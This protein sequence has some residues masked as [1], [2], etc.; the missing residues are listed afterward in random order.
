M[1]TDTKSANP[2]T[3]PEPPA[4]VAGEFNPFVNQ[5]LGVAQVL[6][7]EKAGVIEKIAANRE[8]LRNMATQGFLNTEQA[9]A[10]GEFYPVREHK[11]KADKPANLSHAAKE[12]A[13]NTPTP[14]TA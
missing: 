4:M 9:T 11:P 13:K 8:I 3:T 5:M 2:S 7:D 1:A 6:A 12:V 14:A 10:I